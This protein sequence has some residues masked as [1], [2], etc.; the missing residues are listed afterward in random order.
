MGFHVEMVGVRVE[1]QFKF[2]IVFELK[3]IRDFTNPEPG[4]SHL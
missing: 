1:A 4:M 3:S 2:S